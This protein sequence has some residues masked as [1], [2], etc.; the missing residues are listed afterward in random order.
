MSDKIEVKIAKATFEKIKKIYET[1]QATYEKMGIVSLEGFVGY[2]L[3][4]FCNSSHQF[5]QLNDKMK[6]L[7]ENANINLDSLNYEELFKNI[8]NSFSSEKK[9]DKQTKQET[10]TTNDPDSKKKTKLN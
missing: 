10:S 8:F 9:E 6:H 4:N 5:E 3:E 1:S 7:M 2:V